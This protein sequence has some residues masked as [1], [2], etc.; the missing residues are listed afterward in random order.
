MLRQHNFCSFMP[1][2]DIPTGM[3]TKD[4]LVVLQTANIARKCLFTQEDHD[5]AGKT[6]GYLDRSE[7]SIEF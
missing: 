1:A 3:E 7:A 4:M 5:V 2:I 6:I